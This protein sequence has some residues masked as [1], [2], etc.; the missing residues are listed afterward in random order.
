MFI[1]TVLKNLGC[2]D[3]H[4]QLN[5]I[6]PPKTHS[7]DSKQALGYGVISVQKHPSALTHRWQGDSTVTT[8]WSSVAAVH[9]D[10]CDRS[11]ANSFAKAID[12]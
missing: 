7:R 10:W 12:S 9:Y 3:L 5:A 4:F 2:N 8:R 1:T 6:R 11:S